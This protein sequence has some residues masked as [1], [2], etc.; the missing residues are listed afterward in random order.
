MLTFLNKGFILTENRNYV[1]EVTF[2][3]YA[4][5]HK[6]RM[7]YVKENVYYIEVP[8]IKGIGNET[9]WEIRYEDK[10]QAEEA[11]NKI[12]SNWRKYLDGNSTT[13]LE[14]KLDTLLSH[15]DI[16]PG[17]KEYDIVKQDFEKSI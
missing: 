15:I 1:S 9:T 13:S 4:N 6:V 3:E 11:Y 10:Y 2:V 17:G 5:I 16:I 7:K 14:Q 12:L 8:Y